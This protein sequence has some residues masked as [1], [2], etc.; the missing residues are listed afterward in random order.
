MVFSASERAAA[1]RRTGLTNMLVRQPFQAYAESYAQ[2]V[3]HQKNQL[4]KDGKVRVPE[5]GELTQ[6]Q[7]ADIKRL[8]DKGI[9]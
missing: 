8:G 3:F 5:K 4:L 7:V 1:R 2:T 9:I 6:W